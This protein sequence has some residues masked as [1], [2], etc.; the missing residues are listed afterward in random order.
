MNSRMNYFLGLLSLVIFLSLG[1][2]NATSEQALTVQVNVNSNVAIS[3]S[4]NSGVDNSTMSLGSVQADN[5]QNTWIGGIYGEQLFSYSNVKIDVYTRA[6]GN[7]TD[8]NK[9]IP[10]SNF[11]Y[12]GGDIGTATSFSTNYTRVIDDWD[13]THQGNSNVAPINMYLMVPFGTE[14]G[15]YTTTVY[16]TA[17]AHNSPAP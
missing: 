6:S 13:K 1:S 7:L 4:W 16:F 3:T 10:L 8:G 9:S 12:Q 5:A 11:L 15:N 14:P 2:V 17:V